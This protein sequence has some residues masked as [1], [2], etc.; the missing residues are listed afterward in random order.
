MAAVLENPALWPDLSLVL[1][2]RHKAEV[3]NAE[4]EQS[5]RGAQELQAQG[6][7]SRQA[8]VDVGVAGVIAIRA[9]PPP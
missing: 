3:G 4:R 7:M 5:T 2:G 6:T 9:L 8:G 1:A